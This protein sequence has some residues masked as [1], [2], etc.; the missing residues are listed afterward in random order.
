MGRIRW[1]PRPLPPAI[2]TWADRYVAELRRPRVT[3][4]R[5]IGL[6]PAAGAGLLAGRAIH[7]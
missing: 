2:R 7:D 5:P 6:I 4:G 3:V 1:D